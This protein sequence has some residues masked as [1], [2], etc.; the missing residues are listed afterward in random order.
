MP[1]VLVGAPAGAAHEHVDLAEAVES[2]LHQPLD[3]PVIADVGHD[4]QHFRA[5]LFALFHHLVQRVLLLPRDEYQVRAFPGERDRDGLAVVA[6]RAG[7]QRCL[8]CQL[9]H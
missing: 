7:D 4:R 8:A 9:S 1:E 2:L 5:E 6:P 3:L